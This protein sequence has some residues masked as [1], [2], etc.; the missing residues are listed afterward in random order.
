M[1]ISVEKNLIKKTAQTDM[2][3]KENVNMS[4]INQFMFASVAFQSEL[5]YFVKFEKDNFF[6]RER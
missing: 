4:L 5:L 1:N 3:V 2:C 6:I